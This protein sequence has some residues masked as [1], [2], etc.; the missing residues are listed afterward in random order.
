VDSRGVDDL[1]AKFEGILERAPLETWVA[2]VVGK[3]V[4]LAA[5]VT[6]PATDTLPNVGADT[7]EGAIP[8]RDRRPCRARGGS[9]R[10]APRP[11]KGLRLSD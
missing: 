1:I 10:A 8:P 5:G 3:V 9:V 11:T 6:P 2:T 7:G 4:V